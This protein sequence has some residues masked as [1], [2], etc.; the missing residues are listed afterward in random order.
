MLICKYCNRECVS[1]R[2]LRDHSKAK[3]AWCDDCDRACADEDG[4]DKHFRQASI[5]QGE[6]GQYHCGG[7]GK[8]FH[9][10]SNLR[11]VG[12]VSRGLER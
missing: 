8:N 3:H 7:C 11:E 12:K 5:H 1:Q 9:S 10:L 4:L 2:S 6:D